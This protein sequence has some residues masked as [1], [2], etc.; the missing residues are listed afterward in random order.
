[1]VSESFE[2]LNIPCSRKIADSLKLEKIFENIRQHD[3]RWNVE[4]GWVKEGHRVC[5]QKP[6]TFDERETRRATKPKMRRWAKKV[7]VSGRTL[8]KRMDLADFKLEPIVEVDDVEAV[9][10]LDTSVGWPLAH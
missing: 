1:M 2:Y 4:R 10:Y 6:P 5:F 7:K 8:P 3:C 9:D